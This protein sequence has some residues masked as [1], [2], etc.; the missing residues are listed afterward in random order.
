M[1]WP[2]YVLLV[3]YA[4]GFASALYSI[5]Q[6]GKPR[7]PLTAGMVAGTILVVIAAAVLVVIA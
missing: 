7:G 6:V 5:S 3:W 4:I 1:S 2:K